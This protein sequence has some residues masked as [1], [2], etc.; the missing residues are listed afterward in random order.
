MLL[1]TA[2]N[3]KILK[4]GDDMKIYIVRHGKTKWIEE[5]RTQGR[6]QNRLNEVGILAVEETAKALKNKKI[7]IIYSSPLMR[8]MQSAKIINKYHNVNII[9]DERLTEVDQ[10]VFTGKIWAKLTDEEKKIKSEK[11][12]AYGM[13]SLDEIEAR[14]R[15]FYEGV[16]KNSGYDSILI[17]SH[18]NICTMLEYLLLGKPIDYK[19]LDTFANAEVKAFEV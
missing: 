13:E 10:G 8:T 1:A 11:N 15:D 4:I 7:D 19:S 2:K 5:G 9:K 14:V 3:V 17:V 6:R 18:G 12:K 16:L